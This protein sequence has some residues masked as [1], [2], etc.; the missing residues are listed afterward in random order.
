MTSYYTLQE[1]KT[2][3]KK[4]NKPKQARKRVF[5]AYSGRDQYKIKIQYR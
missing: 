4:K 5:K 2:R 1:K 3:T